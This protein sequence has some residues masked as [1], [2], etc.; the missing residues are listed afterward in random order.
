MQRR[1]VDVLS[2]APDGL[3]INRVKELLYS[4]DPDGGPETNNIIAVM[5]S[6]INRKMSKHGLKIKSS[7]GRFAIYSL[8]RCE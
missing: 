4:N 8:D 7:G 6:Q 1:L 5:A 2:K 3:E